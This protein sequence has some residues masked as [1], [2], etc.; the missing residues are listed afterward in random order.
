MI[1]HSNL[2][3]DCHLLAEKQQDFLGKAL[4]VKLCFKDTSASDPDPQCA[5]ADQIPYLKVSGFQEIPQVEELLKA[6]FGNQLPSKNTDSI[7]VVLTGSSEAVV[8]FENS[9]GEQMC[10][11]IIIINTA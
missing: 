7:E 6:T 3:I 4:T 11:I 2:Y 10:S 1:H 8:D 9:E 5:A